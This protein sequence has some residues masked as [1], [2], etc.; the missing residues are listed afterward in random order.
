MD[1]AKAKAKSQAEVIVETVNKVLSK[2]RCIC[3]AHEYALFSLT[4]LD[5]SSSRVNVGIPFNYKKP[6]AIR[7]EPRKRD[8]DTVE[9]WKAARAK[10]RAKLLKWRNEHIEKAKKALRAAGIRYRAQ[11]DSWELRI[12]F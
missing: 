3:R 8:F 1:Q 5:M 7:N 10:H 2:A 9:Q 12:M 4:S 11:H 6:K